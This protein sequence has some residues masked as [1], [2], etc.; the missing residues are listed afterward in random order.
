MMGKIIVCLSTIP[1]R[2]QQLNLVV[3]RLLR[4]T[5]RPD[6]IR[7]YVPKKYRRFG[8]APEFPKLPAL[9]NIV[10]CP[11]DYGPATKILPALAD[12]QADEALIYCDD[13]IDY[14]HQMIERLVKT[15]EQFPDACIADR[16][17]LWRRVVYKYAKQNTPL[18]LRFLVS[19]A[20]RRYQGRIDI[21]EGYGGVLVKPR[22]FP[23]LVFSVPE[24]CWAVDDMWLS[25]CLEKN[26]TPIYLSSDRKFSKELPSSNVEGLRD[27]SV[28]GKRRNELNAYAIEFMR[29]NLGI[30]RLSSWSISDLVIEQA[31]KKF[32][33]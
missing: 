17:K 3:D 6:E 18:A 4:Q 9:V 27:L 1:P 33:Y 8:E 32:N 23:N 19:K 29:R 7:V 31:M 28:A 5:I 21:A 12:T 11:V 15:S 10:E 14:D 24:A 20:G 25:G 26:G 13:D 16:G 2:S 30:W 22:F